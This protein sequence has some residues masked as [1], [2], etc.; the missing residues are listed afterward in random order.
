MEKMYV[1]QLMDKMDVKHLVILDRIKKNNLHGPV[2]LQ[3]EYGVLFYDQDLLKNF[4]YSHAN[5][6][7]FLKHIFG[8]RGPRNG[9]FL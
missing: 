8:F 5:T 7:L 4:I 6:G 2:F 3:S 1:K 9:Y